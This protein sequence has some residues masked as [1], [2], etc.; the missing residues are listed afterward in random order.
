MK[1]KI[2]SFFNFSIKDFLL[3]I[4]IVGM[5]FLVCYIIHNFILDSESYS[6]LLFMLAIFLV[7]RFTRGYLFGLIAAVVGSFIVNYAFTAPYFELSFSIPGY[8]ITFLIMLL[9]SIFTSILTTKVIEEEKIKIA[10]EKEKVRSNFLR[11]ISHDL[12]TPLTTILGNSNELIKSDRLTEDDKK[13]AEI[14]HSEAETLL[15]MVENV[16]SISRINSELKINTRNELVEEIFENAVHEIKGRY[17]DIRILV[18]IPEKILFVNVDSKL[19]LQVISNLLENAYIHGKSE[20]PI[21]LYATYDSKYVYINVKDYGVGINDDVNKYLSESVYFNVD[22]QN[23]YQGI[24]LSISN[25]II[26]LHGGIIT[27]KNNDDKGATFTIKLPVVKQN[28]K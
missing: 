20:V 21:T 26:K 15:G 19:I 4:L 1:N 25:T 18:Q 10:A 23:K 3:T 14:I 5:A 28:E 8:I 12:R 17:P 27:A 24:G 13:T 9:V 16:L 7:S 6:A 11:S 2:K 22:S